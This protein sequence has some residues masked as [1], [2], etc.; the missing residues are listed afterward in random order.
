MLIWDTGEYEILPYK[1]EDSLPE[2][3]TETESDGSVTSN[4]PRSSM[5]VAAVSPKEKLTD[6]EKLREAFRN[7][8]VFDV[9]AERWSIRRSAGC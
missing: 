1:I 4:E 5:P 9:N 2:T 8:S 7:V 3:E 6:S